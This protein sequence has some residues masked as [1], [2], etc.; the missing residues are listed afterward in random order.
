MTKVLVVGDLHGQY[1]I[2][3]KALATGFPVVFLGDYLDSFNRS[4]EDQVKTLILV[5]SAVR[6]GKATA[7]AIKGNHEVSYL[8]HYYRCSGYSGITQLYMDSIDTSLLK[9]YYWCEGFLLS[10]AGVSQKM[11][12]AEGYESVEEYLT[13]DKDLEENVERFEWNGYIRGGT[14]VCGGLRWCDWRDFVPVDGVN[15]IVGHTRGNEIREK[16]GNYCID[17]LEDRYGDCLGLLI[18]DGKVEVYDFYE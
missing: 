18:E 13:S 3:E 9:D 1:E 17:V 11:L 10:H 6:E 8:D 14:K 2:A 15:Q 4:I 12:D 5:I 7:I 16:D